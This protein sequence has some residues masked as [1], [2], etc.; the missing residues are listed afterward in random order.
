MERSQIPSCSRQLQTC[1]RLMQGCMT[2]AGLSCLVLSCWYS[3]EP[4][5]AGCR[6]TAN[7][8]SR[9]GLIDGAAYRPHG[10]E[11]CWRYCI[12]CSSWQSVPFWNGAGDK[13]SMEL[14]C[15]RSHGSKFEVMICFRSTVCRHHSEFFRRHRRDIMDYILYYYTLG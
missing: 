5:F 11:R 14:C 8:I 4:P 1:A 2:S 3:A 15:N 7:G 6:M 10:L 9:R 12:S 13:R